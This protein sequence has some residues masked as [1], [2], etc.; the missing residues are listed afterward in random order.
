MTL[1][2]LREMLRIDHSTK[3]AHTPSIMKPA[4][5]LLMLTL[6]IGSSAL[7]DPPSPYKVEYQKAFKQAVGMKFATIEVPCCCCRYT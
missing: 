3:K 4:L 6:A 2:F 7:A 1:W 5:I